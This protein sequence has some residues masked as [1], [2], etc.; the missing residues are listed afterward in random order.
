MVVVVT[1][2]LVPTLITLGTISTLSTTGVP[3]TNLPSGPCIYGVVVR[4]YPALPGVSTLGVP[5]SRVS[6]RS[7]LIVIGIS[8]WSIFG[9]LPVLITRGSIGVS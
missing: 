3:D 2:G 5:L 1:V 9:L 4:R 8:F 6:S 7:Y